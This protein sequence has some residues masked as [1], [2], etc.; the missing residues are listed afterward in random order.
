MRLRLRAGPA[1]YRLVPALDVLDVTGNLEAAK[2]GADVNCDLGGDIRDGVPLAGDEWA[3]CEYRVEPFEPL[4]RMLALDTAV[5]GKL[6]EAIL[7]EWMRVLHRA[8][9]RVEDF[10][11]HPPVPHLDEGAVARTHAHHGRL[12]KGHFEVAADGHRFGEI[13]AVVEFEDGKAADRIFLDE[14]GF[15]IL[16]GRQ[17]DLLV[18]DV[19]ALF[20]E[21]N[22]DG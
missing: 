3:L 10:Q 12:G 1:R 19:D 14:P 13:G 22:A 15:A 9:D 17:V 21:E 20:G 5:F 7:E 16:A 11:F 8:G 6:L 18:V 4:D 2:G